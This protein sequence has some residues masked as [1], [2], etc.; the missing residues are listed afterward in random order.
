[1]TSLKISFPNYC[2]N[3]FLQYEIVLTLL[4]YTS[5][6]YTLQCNEVVEFYRRLWYCS[7]L[8]KSN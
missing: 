2:I 7:C 8:S 5:L 1:M 4:T 6:H 3:Q